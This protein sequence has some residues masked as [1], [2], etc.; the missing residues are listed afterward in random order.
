MLY[1]QEP[2]F[3]RPTDS[4]NLF[5]GGTS[6][7]RDSAGA[8]G[9]KMRLH[10]GPARTASHSPGPPQKLWEETGRITV[11]DQLGE[12]DCK[13]PSQPIKAGHGILYPSSQLDRKY[14]RWI[15]L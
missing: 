11:P 8:N 1:G 4:P 9:R 7:K 2:E 3:T 5:L 10:S 13:T 14:N 6:G 15:V 12:R